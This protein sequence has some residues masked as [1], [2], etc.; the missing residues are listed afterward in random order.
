MVASWLRILD[1]EV[2]VR[3]TLLLMA[4]V[5]FPL[6]QPIRMLLAEARKHLYL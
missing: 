3:V 5:R 2:T 1:N 6:L 4:F